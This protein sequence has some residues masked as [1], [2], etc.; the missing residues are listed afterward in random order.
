MGMRESFTS[1]L[2]GSW[3]GLGHGDMG[4]VGGFWRLHGRCWV[5]VVGGLWPGFGALRHARS[6][7]PVMCGLSCHG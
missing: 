6:W 5:P 4:G 3:S 7:S 2:C 1:V